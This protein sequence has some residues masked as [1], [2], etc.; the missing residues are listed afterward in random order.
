M[1]GQVDVTRDQTR[2]ACPCCA[3]GRRNP[4]PQK[5]S[6]GCFTQP[7][8][9]PWALRPASV[10]LPVGPALSGWMLSRVTYCTRM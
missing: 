9:P 10:W 5:A 2:T 3:I 1:L 7:A 4:E 8:P 6:N